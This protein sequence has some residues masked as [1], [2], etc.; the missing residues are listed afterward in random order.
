M[1]LQPQSILNRDLALARRAAKGDRAAAGELLRAASGPVAS[2]M[3]RM[4]AQPATAD[5]LAQDALLAALQAARAYRGEAPF[6]AW[7]LRIA[8]RLYLRRR[9]KDARLE[10]MADPI[11]PATPDGDREPASALRLDLDGALARLSPGERMC[12]SLCHAAGLTHLEIAE[13]MQL[14]LGTVKSHVNRGLAKLRT[15]MADHGERHG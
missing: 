6:T 13:A 15:L 10:L 1:A 11:D 12:V 14:P 4:G 2:L 8:A 7:T 3:R 9:R 5:E